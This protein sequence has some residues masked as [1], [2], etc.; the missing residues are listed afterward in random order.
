[1]LDARILLMKILQQSEHGDNVDR[2]IEI[3]KRT[4][5]KASENV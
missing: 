1:M 2:E 5:S 3:A 4:A